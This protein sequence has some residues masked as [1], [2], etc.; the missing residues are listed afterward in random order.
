EVMEGRRKAPPGPLLQLSN[1]C[2][3]VASYD[4]PTGPALRH[5]RRRI[6]RDVLAEKRRYFISA[7][8]FAWLAV[9][10][11]DERVHERA[12]RRHMVRSCQ[13][14]SP[15]CDPST[16]SKSSPCERAQLLSKT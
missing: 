6:L 16:A 9:D 13:R 15:A 4:A 2:R 12:Q 8:G 14:L 10:A 3:I 5:S 1:A 11:L 7:F